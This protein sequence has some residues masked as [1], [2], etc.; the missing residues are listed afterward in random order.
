MNYIISIFA[1]SAL[2][3]AL[4]TSRLS[5]SDG[6]DHSISTDIWNRPLTLPDLDLST[7]SLS[8]PWPLF[9]CLSCLSSA[10]SSSCLSLIRPASS[11]SVFSRRLACWRVSASSLDSSDTIWRRG[12]VKGLTQGQV[13]GHTGGHVITT[14]SPDIIR[15]IQVKS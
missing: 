9:C 14:N 3:F 10:S 12:Q 1:P 4:L 13:T 2:P 5:S 6:P 15:W 11:V 8:L 7:W